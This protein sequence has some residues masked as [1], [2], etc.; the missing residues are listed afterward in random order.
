MLYEVITDE[1][2]VSWDLN[3]DETKRLLALRSKKY[4]AMG[5]NG[6]EGEPEATLNLYNLARVKSEK[7]YY[8]IRYDILKNHKKQ[9]N[10]VIKDVSGEGSV[11]IKRLTEPVS[12]VMNLFAK[13]DR[14][15]SYNVCYTKLLRNVT[16]VTLS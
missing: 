8:T 5:V 13:K 15:T 2:M 10:K 16:S 12:A 7:V 6:Y 3:K 14:I 4:W 9:V 1:V 11:M